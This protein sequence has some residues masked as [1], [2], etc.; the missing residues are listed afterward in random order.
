MEKWRRQLAEQ[1]IANAEQMAEKKMGKAK[2]PAEFY[3]DM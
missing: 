2:T 1:R 3:S